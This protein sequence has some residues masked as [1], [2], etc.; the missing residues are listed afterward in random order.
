M[1]ML[2]ENIDFSDYNDIAVMQI[3]ALDARIY[4]NI[5]MH[6]SFRFT[7]FRYDDVLTV[8]IFGNSKNF[9][10]ISNVLSHRLENSFY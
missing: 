10:V 5:C 7:S 2:G 8:V 1:Q 6:L 9:V 3:N 4:L